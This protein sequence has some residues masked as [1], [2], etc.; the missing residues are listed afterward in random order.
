[1]KINLSNGV[2]LLFLFLAFTIALKN[3]LIYIYEGIELQKDYKITS[4]YISHLGSGGR[5]ASLPAYTFKAANNKEYTVGIG[6]FK[7]CSSYSSHGAKY[8]IQQIEFP[9]VYSSKNPKV[10][11]IL[12][13][14]KDYQKYN[15]P[16][17]D[18]LRPIIRK[19]FECD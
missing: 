7:F 4:G 6:T 18:T 19:Y 14:K 9:V 16:M 5:T 13:R 17:P 3:R 10:S 11:R 8:L 1:M 2:L 12:L 15:V